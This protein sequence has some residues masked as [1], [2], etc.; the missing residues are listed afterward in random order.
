[1]ASRPPPS[2]DDGGKEKS[3]LTR[4]LA[5]L[6]AQ[7]RYSEALRAREQALRRR[8]DLHLQPSEAQLWLLEGRQAAA[9]GQAKRAE[10]AFRKAL[11]LG[12]NGESHVA[13][14]RLWLDQG[15]ADQALAL[16]RE[17]FDTGDLPPAFAGAYLK[18]LLLAGD[19]DQV[20]ALIRDQPRRFQSH[21]LQW[22]AGAIS[23]LEG[24][25]ANARRQFARMGGAATPGDHGAVWRAWACLEAGDPSGAADALK[26]V[27]HPAC[28]AVA[29]DLVARGGQ[30]PGELVDLTRRDLPRRELALGLALLHH[31]RQ[32]NVLGAAQLLL[33][34]ERTLLSALPELAPLRRPLLRLA[35][36]QALEREAPVEAI[37]CWRPIVDRPSFDADLA[38]RLYPLFDRGDGEEDFQEAERL[39]SQL[40]GWVRRAARDNPSAWPEPLLSTT[41]ARLLCWQ[42]DQHMRL[43]ARQQ[44][45]RCLEQ[46]CQLAPESPDVLGRRGM[47]AF[48]AGE[49]AEAI[50]LLW[51]ALEG[52]CRTEHVYEVLAEA[53]ESTGQTAERLRL[54]QRYGTL[55]ND[56][57]PP[58]G[59]RDGGIPA[60]LEALAQPDAALLA[61]ALR[62][63]P[64]RGAALEALRILVEHVSLPSSGADGAKPAGKPGKV[65]LAL[66]AA[67]DRWD[68]LLA[69][70]Q[71]AE[72]VEALTAVLAAIH[73][74]C[75]RVGKPLASEIARRQEQLERLA[76]ELGSAHG[77]QA[78]R[79]LLL[80]HGL[81]LKRSE[82]P[83]PEM[84]RLLRRAHQPERALPLALLDLRLLASTTPWRAMVEDLLR[85]DPQQ[86]LLML[87]L[88][89]MERTGSI[90]YLQLSQ[91]AFEQARRQQDSL[92]LAACGREGQWAE[93]HPERPR[94]RR[95]LGLRDDIDWNRLCDLMD[96]ESILR[97]VVRERGGGEHSDADVE[98]LLPEIEPLARRAILQMVGQEQEEDGTSAAVD[99]EREPPRRQ[100]GRG[101]RRTFMDL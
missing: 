29:L 82:A 94:G 26:G 9:E 39:A 97:D 21:Q 99:G 44:T 38:L 68:A 35:G 34:H 31:L 83:G 12:W 50:P 93:A 4:K 61:R 48:L 32:Q 74:F 23:L 37:A 92:A 41:L 84:A 25:P 69:P 65:S 20:R 75:R 96:F 16:I 80:L 63:S 24:D 58:E 91:E 88:A 6:V 78:L 98:T 36:Q 3:A 101:P 2:P 85:Q 53:L 45:L 87:A 8:P 42:A 66:P 11:A 73:R 47:V 19:L 89:T 49:A 18:L 86:P 77:D 81:R 60:W 95:P 67:A 14:A 76:A 59:E 51:Q 27:D 30:H 56:A 52:G 90:A 71:P 46:A 15:K 64:E 70:L 100:R 17:A 13:L 79:A 55:F 10:G 28:A 72:Q 1:M 33:A 7:R 57:P 22:A 40:L 54:R 43:G 62:T 5:D